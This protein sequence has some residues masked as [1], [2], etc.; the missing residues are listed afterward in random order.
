MKTIISRCLETTCKKVAIIVA[1]FIGFFAAGM[2]YGSVGEPINC[3]YES[4]IGSL[5]QTQNIV[6]MFVFGTV[7]MILAATNGSGLI[8]GEN[9]DGTLRLL[10]AKPNTRTEILFAKVIGTFTGCFMLYGI[11]LLGYY[12]FVMIFAPYDG[13]IFKE[14][15]KYFVGYLVY[16]FIVILVVLAISTLLS[17]LLK[18]R[19][20]ALLPILAIIVLIVAF[21][22]L[23]RVVD[24]YS[25][26]GKGIASIFDLNYHFSLIFKQSLAICGGMP[27]CPSTTMVFLTNLYNVVLSDIDITGNEVEQIVSNNSLN[28]FLVTVSYLL[29]SVGCYL[30]ALRI[31]KHKDI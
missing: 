15:L 8:A 11:M 26:G 20:F 7:A 16:G 14:M 5:I 23:S 13:L 1:I 9:A 17:C 22:P 28:S 31:F 30:G 19:I 12:A 24:M 27:E 4:F 18:K 3:S 29:I 25:M 10:V 21:Y 2:L 6:V